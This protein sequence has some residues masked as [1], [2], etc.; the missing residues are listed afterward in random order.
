MKKIKQI[1]LLTALVL[2][3]GVASLSSINHSSFV[4]DVAAV[5]NPADG[6]SYYAT[7]QNDLYYSGIDDSLTGED[8]I[9]AL[10]TLTSTGFVGKS[11]SSLPSIYQHS[12][13]SL[14]DSSKMVMVYTG[15]EKS[16]SPGGMPANTNKE[17][18]WPASW[19]GNGDRT[20][21]SGSP[22]ADAHNVWPSAT[23]L[24]SK[25]GSCA[26]D[27]LD[28][29][30]SFK[31][32]EFSA[33]DWSY[34]TPGDN[35][36]YVW[37]TAFNN[38][39]GQPDDALY[40][41]RGHRGAIARVLMYVATRYRNNTTYPV[42]LHDQ[43][44]T[45]KSG[46]IG[47]LSSLLKWHYQEPPSEWEIKRNNE[48]AS[49]WHH[50]RNPFVDHPE[51]ATKIYYHLPEPGASTPTAAVKS[52]IETYGD[53]HQGIVLDHSSLSLNIGQSAKI[54]IVSNP[55][56]ET[57]S[58][59]SDNINVATVDNQGNVSAINAGTA[60][61]TANGSASSASCNV[62]V[63][64][65]NLTIPIT[66][67]NLN[68]TTK[69]M[70]IGEEV[71]LLPTISPSN[72]T[73]K[74]LNWTSSNT[75]V[76]IVNTHGHIVAL[77]EG[78]ATITA[79]ASDGSGKSATCTVTVTANTPSEG[80]WHLVTE[81]SSLAAGDRLV[82][83]SN[84]GFTAGNI[85]T[86]Y[87]A[88]LSSTFSA[89]K[90]TITTLNAST[91]ELTLGGT[92]GEWTLENNQSA[93]LGSTGAKAISWNGGTTTWAISISENNATISNSTTAN[94][95]FLYNVS[96]PRFTTYASSTGTSSSM[97]LPQLYRFV[98]ET[99]PAKEG[100]YDY[101]STFMNTTASECAALDVKRSTWSTLKSGYENL[102]DESKNY[103]YE[104]SENDVLIAAMVER[105][106][107]IISKYG[108]DN[109]LTDALGNPVLMALNSGDGID[110]L[111]SEAAIAVAII[112]F[113]GIIFISL[114]GFLFY[115]KTK[116]QIL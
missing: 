47:K 24:N 93:L 45:L 111:G 97:L 48:V 29:A 23:A 7:N 103:I 94:G 21:S 16:F 31:S 42:K 44:V 73:N 28:F 46:R 49:R 87:M 91:I 9:V 86:T 5:S 53:L 32:Y 56:D 38:S 83:A 63:T 1:I 106:A 34:G 66:S 78:T 26:F 35:D 71:A 61:I 114:A 27:E 102:S 99:D 105:Y 95:R 19:Y 109:F 30:S 116:K 37:S 3:A 62:T 58:W 11:Y 57:I 18:V 59:S 12:D 84:N 96:S 74:V 92:A 98:D 22:G 88:S 101:I 36:S 72:A 104:H 15:T 52:V 70:Q 43:A 33:T 89:D 40:P 6:A 108:Y 112:S 65:P 90:Q 60:K 41:A 81:A 10:S 39:N 13:A 67:I 51:Y 54:N 82:I 20:E 55:N 2:T 69:S 80:G 8:L 50:N 113:A 14:S 25:R 76:A 79:S 75:G 107:V 17:H 115:Q 110:L 68:L 100:A 77:S 85:S 4:Q 64:D